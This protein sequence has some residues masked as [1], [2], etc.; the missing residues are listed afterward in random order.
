MSALSLEGEFRDVKAFATGAG[1]VSG[2]TDTKYWFPPTASTNHP[3]AR[4]WPAAELLLA[5]LDS[6]KE[7]AGLVHGRVLE[8]GAG[9]GWLGLE[10]TKRFGKMGL[11][12]LVLTEPEADGC[13]EQ[14]KECVTKNLPLIG[15]ELGHRVRCEG[16]EWSRAA[17]ST[18][19]TETHFD[20]VIATDCAYSL[21]GL[22]VFSTCDARSWPALCSLLSLSFSTTPL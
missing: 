15:E 8:L 21:R 16:L 11:D 14:L 3:S 2:Q 13:L 9:T 4:V 22:H 12:E 7:N 20:T 10:V 18:L 5:F 17:S 6:S 1:F 19:L